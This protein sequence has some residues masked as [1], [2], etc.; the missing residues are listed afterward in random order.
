MR[1][2]SKTTIEKILRKAESLLDSGIL[3]EE[4][5]IKTKAV[6]DTC[7]ELLAYGDNY[8]ELKKIFAYMFKDKGNEE[9]YIDFEAEE[10]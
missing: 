4:Q 1:I 9:Y 7:N 2:I 3:D 5:E 8:D 6:S 10:E